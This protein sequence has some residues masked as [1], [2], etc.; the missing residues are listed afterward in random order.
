MRRDA[1]GTHMDKSSQILEARIKPHNMTDLPGSKY[2][3]SHVKLVR[4]GS[5][6][7]AECHK[8]SIVPT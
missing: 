1:R 5:P 4:L 8:E 3:M 7:K 2:H 6:N